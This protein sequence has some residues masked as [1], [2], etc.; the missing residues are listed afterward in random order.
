MERIDRVTDTY[1]RRAAVIG[2]RCGVVACLLS[3]EKEGSSRW[4]VSIRICSSKS[5]FN[6]MAPAPASANF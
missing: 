5:D 3:G 1:R 6:T 2:M 4:S